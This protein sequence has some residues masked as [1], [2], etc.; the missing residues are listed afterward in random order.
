M[1]I[2]ALAWAFEQ[3][4][5]PSSKKFVLVALAN[6]A[7]DDGKS[8]PGVG[9]IARITGHTEDTV[10]KAL[11][12]LEKAGYIKDTT[13]RKGSTHQIKV[14]LLPEE[15]WETL[16]KKGG[17]KRG[18]FLAE[19]PL[20]D[21]SKTPETTEPPNIGNREPGTA[22][23]QKPEMKAF[24][25]GWVEGYKKRFGTPYLFQRD[26]D[27][28]AAARLLKLGLGVAELLKI[29]QRAWSTEGFHCSKASS[30]AGFA[31]SFNDINAE[32]NSAPKVR[33]ARN[34]GEFEHSPYPRHVI[35]AGN[36]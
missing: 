20:K 35:G 5:L 2:R 4:T 25:D 29:A 17:L 36:Y 22:P 34:K 26:K 30:L 33:P 21:P 32:L 24:T 9:T 10:R 14:Y 8:Y 1:S 16:P 11:G 18:P 6:F 13:Q 12:E 27:G 19:D 31:S 15:T 7:R 23:A 3:E 28:T